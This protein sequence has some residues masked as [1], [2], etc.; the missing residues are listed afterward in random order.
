[1]PDGHACMATRVSETRRRPEKQ[2][3]REQLYQSELCTCMY[4]LSATHCVKL[5]L[6][7]S[8]SGFGAS[9]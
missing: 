8:F 7:C 4:G 3:T 9:F 5:V 6:L 2:E 1:M